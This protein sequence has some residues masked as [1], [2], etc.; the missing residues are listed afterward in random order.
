MAS[1]REARLKPEFAHLYPYLRP[2]I[3][4]PAAMLTDRV[5]ASLLGRPGGKFITGDRALDPAHFEFRGSDDRRPPD[6]WGPRED[7]P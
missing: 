3:W 7:V 6:H 1:H 4:E 5:V 2:G